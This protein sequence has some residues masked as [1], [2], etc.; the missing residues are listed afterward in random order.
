MIC[1]IYARKSNE[2]VGVADDGKSVTRQ[3]EHCIAYAE[4]KGWEVREEF[5]FVDDGIS[6]AEFQKRPGFIRLMNSLKPKP[7]FQVLVMSEESRLGREQ[8]QTAY[9]LQQLMD[10]G[11]RVFFYLTDQERTLN[12]AMD[13]V[14]LSLTNFAAEMEREKAQQRVYDA[15]IRKAKAGHVTGGKVFGYDNHVVAGAVPDA[16]GNPKRS[17]VELRINEA[18][19]DV[20]RKIFRLYANGLGFTSIA[21]TLNAEGAACPRPRPLTRPR[22]WAASSVRQI[23][24]RRLYKGEQVWN[25]TKKR[26]PSGAKKARWRPESQWLVIPVP[27][28]RIIP[29]E[30]WTQA[31]E[32][33]TH[34]RQLYLRA[35]NGRVHGRPTNGHESR[36]LLTGFST[37]KT[38][39]G[40]L[41]VQSERRNARRTHYYA[42][43][44]HLR[45]GAA[46][47]AEAMYAPMEALDQAVLT[48][49]EED[50]LHP[51]VLMKAI[52]KAIQQLSPQD[53]DESTARR[54][55]IKKDLAK[56]EAALA[57]LTQA[58][59]EGGALSTLLAEM[60]KLEDQR[61]RLSGDLAMLDGLAVTSFDPM[62]VEEELRGYLKDWSGL[63]Q[64]H[65]AQTR[66]I[67]RKL[68]P[69][70]IRVWREVRGGEKVYRFE[71]EAAVGKLFN[72]LV[73]IERSGVPNGI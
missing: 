68:L 14:M 29:S 27:H 42:C 10:A 48:A 30:L 50:V 61:T 62:R 54:S 13:K 28:L 1:A 57:R 31:Q 32:R 20:V 39:N 47:C 9:A 6:G 36:Y 8:I 7:P 52:E 67:L 11:V 37:C 3:T 16:Q 56:V 38:C 15:M 22:G 19:A 44:T 70:R 4:S 45:R 66:Q 18:E 26:L 53:D 33:W 41:C 69:N 72:G 46:A 12:T 63:A 34:V 73:H 51:A 71:G 25:R 35:T 5:I 49:I 24:L 23:I 43:T 40:S 59:V 2:Q 58:V 17:H 65:P 55:A 21:K 64:R 60:K